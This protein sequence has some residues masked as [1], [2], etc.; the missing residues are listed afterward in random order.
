MRGSVRV[1]TYTD[2]SEMG[3]AEKAL[4]TLV[5]GLDDRIDLTVVGTNSAIVEEVAAGRDDAA[6]RVVRPVIDK[7][8]IGGSIAHLRLMRDLRPDV[9]HASI[10]QPWSCRYALSA[11]VLTPGVRTLAVHNV[12]PPSNRRPGEWHKQLSLRRLDAHVAVSEAGARVVEQ[13]IGLGEG[14]VGVIYNGVADAAVTARPRVV[15]GPVVGYVGR[16]SPEKGLDVLLR[17]VRSLPEVT[18]ILVGDGPDRHRLERLGSE[19]GISS[20]VR[21]LG[22]Q[23]D[24]RPWFPGFDVFAL[25]SRHEALGLAAVEAM[26]AELPVVASAVGGT[27]EVVADGD[28]GILVPPDDPDA[29]AAALGSLLADQ[30]RRQR[31]GLLGRKIARERFDLARMLREYESLYDELLH[32]AGGIEVRR[33]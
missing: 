21:M 16:L 9:L 13:A 19:L 14:A 22:W 20:R 30:D 33:D 32:S 3:G 2:S 31:M 25:P 26:L 10:W 1:A 17:A 12:I 23:A 5:R 27:P 29:L 24:P 8:D 6:T 4:A 18:A 15:E 11:A 7:W 28:S